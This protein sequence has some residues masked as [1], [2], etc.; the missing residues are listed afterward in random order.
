MH[1]LIGTDGQKPPSSALFYIGRLKVTCFKLTRRNLEAHK[2]PKMVPYKLQIATSHHPNIKVKF[3]RYR[4]SVAQRVGR[5]IAVHFHER[6]TR[7]W[8]NG[9]QH[10]PAA[11]YPPRN[12]T[13]PIV[14]KAG[15]APWPVS[16]SICK[17]GKPTAQKYRYVLSWNYSL[18]NYVVSKS[19]IK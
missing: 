19:V 8:V 12:G 18:K 10:A 3:S 13:L 2:T 17:L 7:K 1:K 9:Q 16:P 11:I 6:F 4:P 5:I 15:L 14:E